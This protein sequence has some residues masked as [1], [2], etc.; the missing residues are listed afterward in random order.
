MKHFFSSILFKLNIVAAI[1]L[2]LS[3]LSVF[4]SPQHFWPLAIF[5][6]LYPYLFIINVLFVFFW[7]FVL[8]KKFLLSLIVVLLG[9]AF[10]FRNIQFPLPFAK[11]DKAKEAPSFKV[12]S[13]N[14]RLFNLYKWI[15]LDNAGAEIS[16]YVKAESPDIICFQEFYTKERGSLTEANLFRKLSPAKYKH[17]RYTLRKPGV[18]NF[19]IATFSRFPIINTGEIKFSNTFNQCIYTDIKVGKDTIRLYNLHLQSYRLRKENYEFLDSL[20]FAY[21]AKQVKGLKNF[22]YRVKT[23]YIKRSMQADTVAA[24]ILASPYPVI[25]CGDLN[26]S[27]VS[28]T[29]QKISSG[30]KDAFIESGTGIGSTYLSRFPSFRIDY[31]LHS[32]K[33][34]AFDYTI[35]KIGLS[36][37]YPVVC[38]IRNAERRK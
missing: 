35:P 18:S 38:K 11:N 8:R 7:A 3:Y 19:G 33:L 5:G 6:L 25:V 23:A 14:V 34:Q 36:D 4:V 15:K 37:H 32:P 24:H 22:T 27:P 2:L 17:I 28:Y 9:G 31:I 16:K 1:L 26:D 13:F 12:M 21:N 10:L 29:Y 20:K 30:L